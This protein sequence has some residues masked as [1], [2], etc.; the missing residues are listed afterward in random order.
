M[1][2]I[3]I[4]MSAK[5]ALSGVIS[6]EKEKECKATQQIAVIAWYLVLNYYNLQ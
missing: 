6:V 4:D 2:F 1:L 5:V 3:L